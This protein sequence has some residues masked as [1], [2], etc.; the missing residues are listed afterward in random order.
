M[1]DKIFVIIG[2]VLMVSL[3]IAIMLVIF[4]TILEFRDK[5]KN[6]NNGDN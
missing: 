6:K 2:I 3:M 4:Y 5:I 1:L